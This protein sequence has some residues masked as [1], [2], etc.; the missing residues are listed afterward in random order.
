MYRYISRESCSQFDSLPLTSL[1]EALSLCVRHTDWKEAKLSGFVPALATELAALVR[2]SVGASFLATRT[3]TARF[4]VAFAAAAPKSA[5][6]TAGVTLTRA[7]LDGVRHEKQSALVRRG[8]VEAAGS[9]AS[10]APS[11]AR[12]RSS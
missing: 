9:L 2:S 5:V 11:Q 4:I 10:T 12:C 7:L 8:F 6:K 3:S 1:T